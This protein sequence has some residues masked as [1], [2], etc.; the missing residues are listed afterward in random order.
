MLPK[1]ILN[2]QTIR[3]YY[4]WPGVAEPSFPAGTDG[5]LYFHHARGD[6]IESQIRFRLCNTLNEFQNGEDLRS[7]DGSPWKISL[8]TMARSPDKYGATLA[9][10]Q[11]EFPVEPQNVDATHVSHRVISTFD[12]Q[13]LPS[14]GQVMDISGFTNA[15][16]H[17]RGSETDSA[18]QL[19]YK[20][21]R[22]YPPSTIGVYYYKQSRTTPTRL[23]ELRFRLCHNVQEF[24]Q[25]R[26]LCFPTGDPWCI[27]SLAIY[28]L[29]RHQVLRD[30]L[31]H[32]GLLTG[33]SYSG[34]PFIFPT[35]TTRPLRALGDPFAFDLSNHHLGLDIWDDCYT[36]ASRTVLQYMFQN[37]DNPTQPLFSGMLINFLLYCTITHHMLRTRHSATGRVSWSC[38]R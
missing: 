12:P 34:A 2:A 23:G 32:E 17:L 36:T 21:L 16:I 5:V 13:K 18:T 29:K 20:H 11:E 28:S 4:T 26:D 9:L 22:A 8:K 6:N 15:T 31:A 38:A 33:I 27:S 30:F 35:T 7:P 37:P 14:L 24:A 10:L 1:S 19:Y 3:L 25:G